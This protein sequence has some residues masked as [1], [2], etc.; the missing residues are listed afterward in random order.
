MDQVCVA[1]LEENL[2]V[3]HVLVI[4]GIIGREKLETGSTAL[5][6]GDE[7]ELAHSKTCSLAF[8]GP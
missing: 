1:S 2:G 6:L 5:R 3:T 4:R 8:Y 7:C